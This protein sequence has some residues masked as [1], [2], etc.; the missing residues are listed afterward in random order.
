MP[1]VGAYRAASKL[2]RDL[3]DRRTLAECTITHFATEH[4][5][6]TDLR[7]LESA[8][9]DAAKSESWA[10]YHAA[11]ERFHRGLARASKQE[12]AI[13]QHA[14]ALT[15]LYRYFL[16]YPIEDLHRSNEDHALILDGIRRGDVTEAVNQA[17]N[18][19]QKLH[20][21]MFVALG[22]GDR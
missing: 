8:I 22:E 17:R 15:E 7:E 5:T 3:I 21:T 19:S 4:A 9:R 11:D 13:A 12:W 14:E 6:K 16:P 2:V 10:D 20:A 1:E 18:H